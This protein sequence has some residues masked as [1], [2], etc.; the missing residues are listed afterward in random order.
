MLEVYCVARNKKGKTI[1]K[2][3]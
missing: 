3:L 2:T 1:K